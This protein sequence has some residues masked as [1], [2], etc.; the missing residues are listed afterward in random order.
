MKHNYL[1]L[2]CGNRF[3]NQWHNIDFISNNSHVKQ[4]NLLKGIPFQSNF[5][6]VVYHSHVL[7]HFSKKDGEIFI[8]ECFRV[9]KPNGI[10]RIA[11]PDLEMIAREYIKNLE[12][13][14]AGEVNAK[15]NY[16]WILLEMYD[17]TVRKSSGGEMMNYLTKKEIKNEEY[18]FQRIGEEGRHIRKQL[19]AIK[20]NNG[21]LDQL[22]KLIVQIANGNMFISKKKRAYYEIGKFR[23]SGEI[24]QWMYDRYSLTNLLLQCGFMQVEVKNAFISKIP[25]WNSFELD[26]K[27]G[28]VFKP[29]SLFIEAVKKQ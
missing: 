9:L 18:V 15:H 21:F 29:D 12:S 5:F 10:L 24:H 25:D 2:G 17:Q 1:N 27:D 8:N 3:H 13:A 7:E 23:M 4:H 6:D 11:V 16:E 26:S 22:K 19:Q 20:N 28:V 14:L